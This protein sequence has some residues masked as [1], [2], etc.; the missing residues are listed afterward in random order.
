MTE[1]EEEDEADEKDV[2]NGVHTVHCIYIALSR[3]MYSRCK[4]E[5]GVKGGP[6]IL[7]KSECHEGRRMTPTPGTSLLV[8]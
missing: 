5:R 6:S 2:A 8:R 4:L 1:L 7:L 3:D